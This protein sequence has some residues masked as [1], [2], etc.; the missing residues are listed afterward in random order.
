MC[1]IMQTIGIIHFKN[2][3]SF[4][5]HLI[6][7][8]VGENDEIGSSIYN[9]NKKFRLSNYE[10]R[11]FLSIKN[12]WKCHLVNKWDFR[13]TLRLSMNVNNGIYD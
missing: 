12:T 13:R 6:Q 9:I 5:E 10:F 8:D 2:F 7:I 4:S 1:C 3:Q 11:P